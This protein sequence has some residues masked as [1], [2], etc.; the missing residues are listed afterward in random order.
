MELERRTL[1]TLEM[2]AAA[3]APEKK[4]MSGYAAKFNSLSLPL[5]PSWMR[6]REKIAPGAFD[7]TL[8]KGPDVRFT[9][10]HDPNFVMGR[11]AAGTLR[12]SVDSTGLRFEADPPDNETA[13]SL[14]ESIRRGD[15][16]QCS[17]AFR[18]IA[19]EWDEDE[20]GL[21]IRTLTKVSIDN[22]DV[23]AV[24][25]PAYE[26]TEVNARSLDEVAKA[27]QARLKKPTDLK[28]MRQRLDLASL[29]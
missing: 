29:E 9:L 26:D 15:I 11:T 1:G 3:D 28:A 17:F 2:R 14:A 16:N 22:G 20:N 10:N 7:E 27:G 6:F 19:D 25:Y 5:G 21:A 4:T 8:A 23:A 13:R 18:T 12:L 24:T